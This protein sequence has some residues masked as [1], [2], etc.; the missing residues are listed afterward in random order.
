MWKNDQKIYKLNNQNETG[1]TL[2]EL[3]NELLVNVFKNEKVISD[4][5]ICTEKIEACICD[6]QKIIQSV[7]NI[8]K[9][10]QY[11]LEIVAS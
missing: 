3:M 6:I 4:L 1:I 8:Q 11:F 9:D 10:F 7:K 5:G 2:I